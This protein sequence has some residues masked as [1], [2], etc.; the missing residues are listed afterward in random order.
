[1][2]VA[3]LGASGFV[4]AHLTRALRNRGDTV[5]AASLRDPEAAAQACA[6]CDAIVNLAGEPIAQ[7][8]SEAVKRRI[9]QSRIEAPRRFLD[10]LSHLGRR[11][12]AYVSASAIGYY[13]SSEDETF[14]ET[15]PS[16]D[17][18]LARVCAGWEREARA[19]SD[20]GMRV[21]IVRSGLALGT[22][23][24]LLAKMLPP[25]RAGLG[26][27]VGSGRQWISWV[28]VDDLAGIFC[29]ALD[30]ADGPL[31][32]TAPNPVTNAQLTKTLGKVLHRP[33]IAP[34]PA[35]VLRMVLGEGAQVALTGQ[36]VLPQ[37]TMELGYRFRFPEL[38]PALEDLL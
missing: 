14:T 11:V 2:N 28:H 33:T 34:V 23:G 37:R 5:V 18:F 21:A 1:V 12:R 25:F 36:R 30:G 10:A 7:R 24:G 32:A 27:I 22:D 19:A 9:E 17:D 4:G 20:L 15:N 6:P 8:W 35:I 29:M 3:V 16:G 38:E 31:N 13:G 26:G